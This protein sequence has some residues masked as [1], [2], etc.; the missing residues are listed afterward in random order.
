MTA[1]VAVGVA[2]FKVTYIAE[3]DDDVLAV[4]KDVVGAGQPQQDVLIRFPG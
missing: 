4:D 2:T 3:L 1:G